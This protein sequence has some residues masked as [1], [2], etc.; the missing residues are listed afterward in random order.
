MMFFE[1][2]LLLKLLKKAARL[3]AKE[4][5]IRERDDALREKRRD[6]YTKR[7]ALSYNEHMI[8][9]KLH[10]KHYIEK[11]KRQKPLSDVQR[12]VMEAKSKCKD[13]SARCTVRLRDYNRFLRCYTKQEKQYNK[14][15][16][17][18]NNLSKILNKIEKKHLKHT[19]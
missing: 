1:K 19:S 11:R 6:L 18:C 9:E 2:I 7:R 5:E 13:L 17:N 8:R 3:K 16:R 12:R 14:A 15:K 4:D 10:E